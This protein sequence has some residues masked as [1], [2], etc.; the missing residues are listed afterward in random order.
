MQAYLLAVY[1]IFFNRLRALLKYVGDTISFKN[2]FYAN[3][4]SQRKYLRHVMPHYFKKSNSANDTEEICIVYGSDATTITTVRNWFK[5]FRAGNFDLKDEDRN[6]CLTTTD[7]DLIKTMLAE[8]SRYSVR[9]IMDITNIPRTTVHNHL[10]RMG[11]IN[12]C[13]VW[14]L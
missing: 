6:G 9:K 2:F 13:K 10:I 8:N 5:R 4:G 3:M 1:G 12:R 11:Y 14:I 7:T